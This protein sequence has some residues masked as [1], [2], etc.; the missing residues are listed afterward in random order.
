MAKEIT[1]KSVSIWQRLWPAL[2]F[3]VGLL[4]LVF[5][6]YDVDSKTP[7]AADAQ[8]VSSTAQAR[9]TVAKK[10]FEECKAKNNISQKQWNSLA[11]EFYAIYSEYKTW[12]NRPAA[13]FRNAMV[14]ERIAERESDYDI[15]IERYIK[16]ATEFSNSLL[17]DDALLQA[18]II[19]GVKLNRPEKSLELLK[20]IRTNLP[21]GD[22][23]K[24][25]IALEKKLSNATNQVAS[26]N[27][28]NTDKSAQ[29]KMAALTQVSW[30]TLDNNTVQITVALDKQV[31][32]RVFEGKG[33][34]ILLVMENT[35]P[36]KD[37]HKG[38]RVK[39]S[40]LTKLA[41]VR[42]QHGNTDLKLDFTQVDNY[43]TKIEQ[44][45]FR[46][47]LIATAKTKP[48]VQAVAPSPIDPKQMQKAAAQAKLKKNV[49]QSEHTKAK[50][51]KAS[52]SKPVKQAKVEPKTNTKAKVNTKS[53]A[54]PK[55]KPVAKK[56][57]PT[58]VSQKSSTKSEAK[59]VTSTK[60]VAARAYVQP[61]E[62]KVKEVAIPTEKELSKR[63]QK[64]NTKDMAMQLGL[65]VKT[66][67][68][69]I[70]HGGRD[71]GAIGNGIVERDIVLDV[72]LRL[73]K[74]LKKQGLNVVYSRTSNVSVPLSVRPVQANDAH[75]DLF[76]SIHV[77]ANKDTR[78][79]GFE[80]Y[81][82]N[83]AKNSHAAQTAALENATSDR[84]LGDI[85]SLL[86]NVMLNV[87]TSES[88]ELAEDV[89]NSTVKRLRNN[90]Y[91]TKNAG[92]RSA[93][94]HVLIDTHM[95]A[96]LVEVGYCSNEVEAKKLKNPKYRSI[97][98][99]G[100]A[101]G[102][103]QY[104]NRLEKGHGTHFALTKNDD[105]AM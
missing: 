64:S 90:G 101:E 49:V 50:A 5:F 28:P 48:S 34:Q 68:I 97:L 41:I 94:F 92:T 98:A 105:G 61:V 60:P 36:A 91:N 65:S 63:V 72:G 76:V 30:V 2:T 42:Q 3:M 58:K 26:K 100:I 88:I 81:F 51:K 71:P 78:V 8:P 83:F 86:A 11:D 35:I 9:Y 12:P 87:R 33:E 32:W 19:Q 38:A 62:T 7:V 103:M 77:N 17:A 14:L 85:Q 67:F 6:F 55:V 80:T 82:L 22:M 23:Y 16:L 52:A 37:V 13:L 27:R 54:G 59:Q 25:A 1:T 79:H 66:V 31:K 10:V 96:I 53:K 73:G 24:K 39:N 15:V 44:N 43:K 21:K 47:I 69:D 93:P 74:I 56:A 20:Y 46:I 89:L 102:I 75:A 95:P 18:A 84:K 40:L 4:L 70:G 99:N 104:K 45:P 57:L 29:E